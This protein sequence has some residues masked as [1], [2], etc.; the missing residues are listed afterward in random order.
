LLTALGFD[1]KERRRPQSMDDIRQFGIDANRPWLDQR[2]RGNSSTPELPPD[3]ADLL[4]RP[5]LHWAGNINVLVGREAVERHVAQALRIYPGRRNV[6]MMI[7]GDGR[8]DAYRFELRGLG[9]NWTAFLSRSYDLSKSPGEC[10]EYEIELGTWHQVS[11]PL[12]AM[13]N[14]QPPEDCVAGELEV[15]VT[16]K[17]SGESAIVEF[18]LDPQAQGPGCFVA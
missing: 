6:A 3:P 17:S 11:R 4:G 5:N 2:A 16:R 7:V 15:H 1:D 13:L 9:A 14:I 10:P 12:C 8:R 18:S